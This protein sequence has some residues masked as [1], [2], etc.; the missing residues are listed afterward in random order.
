MRKYLEYLACVVV[1]AASAAAVYFWFEHYKTPM[2]RGEIES[3]LFTVGSA[4]YSAAMQQG[5]K[6]VEF[7]PLPGSAFYAGGVAFRTPE[8]ALEWLVHSG[9]YDKG[10]RVYELTG[11]FELDTHMVRGLPHTNKSLLVSREVP[12]HP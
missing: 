3:P 2:V 7:G 4:D 1:V 11:D 6:V 5:K 9:K 10:W 8:E 12:I